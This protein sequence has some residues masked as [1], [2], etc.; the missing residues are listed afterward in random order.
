MVGENQDFSKNSNIPLSP[1]QI[2]KLLSSPEGAA[3]IRLLQKDG[4]KGIQTA[5]AS[6]RR[7]DPEGAK[8]ALAPLLE[9]TDGEALADRLGGSL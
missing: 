8:A 6:L 7:G 1:A 5:A 4:G 3:L 9:G 2:R